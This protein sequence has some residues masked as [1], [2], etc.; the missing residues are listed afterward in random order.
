M[1]E[2][3]MPKSHLKKIKQEVLEQSII[4]VIDDDNFQRMFLTH[5]FENWGFKNII[6]A[7][8]GKIGW[9]KTLEV[10][11][12]LVLLDINM[13]NMNGFDYCKTARSHPDHKDTTIFIQTGFTN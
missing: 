5:L 12:D 3:K 11:P 9:E 4:L 10:K 6:E 8:D 1:H 13:P 7:E 2:I